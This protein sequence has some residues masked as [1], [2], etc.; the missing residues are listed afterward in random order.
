MYCGDNVDG[1]LEGLRSLGLMMWK[2]EF[3]QDPSSIFVKGDY[4]EWY[5]AFTGFMSALLTS[6][7][8]NRLA[9]KYIVEL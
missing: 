8:T 7:I 5:L 9:I 4:F 3:E 2:V 6:A 1:R